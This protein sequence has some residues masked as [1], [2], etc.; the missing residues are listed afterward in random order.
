NLTFAICRSSPSGISISPTE[1]SL[2]IAAAPPVASEPSGSSGKA[3]PTV[4]TR[5]SPS[6]LIPSITAINLPL[7]GISDMTLLTSVA[8]LSTYLGAIKF[9]NQAGLNN[10]KVTASNATTSSALHLN[11]NHP[12]VAAE[13]VIAARVAPPITITSSNQ[14]PT[15]TKSNNGLNINMNGRT[16]VR[17]AYITPC[18]PV[19]SGCAPD[20]AEAANVASPTGGVISAIMPK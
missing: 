6:T 13:K 2:C 8:G 10:I 11:L 19:A 3:T 12:K 17:E 9:I 1:E 18:I 15:S 7:C 5:S 4:F 20:I 14:E 16:A